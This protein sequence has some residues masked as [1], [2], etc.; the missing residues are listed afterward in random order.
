MGLILIVA[1]VI[2]LV[3]TV[4]TTPL[5]TTSSTIGPE[6]HRSMPKQCGRLGISVCVIG[7][8]IGSGCGVNSIVDSGHGVTIIRG[9][10]LL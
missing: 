5:T 9:V 3:V 8:G 2:I 10:M 6:R 4:V 1:V 7:T